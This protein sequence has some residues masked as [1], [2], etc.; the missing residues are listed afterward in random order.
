[1]SIFLPSSAAGGR[2]GA[3]QGPKITHSKKFLKTKGSFKIN[4]SWEGGKTA[5]IS[6]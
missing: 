3:L 6:R 2:I 1:L 4:I 5:T